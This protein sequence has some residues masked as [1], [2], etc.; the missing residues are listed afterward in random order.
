MKLLLLALGSFAAM[1]GSCAQPAGGSPSLCRIAESPHAFRGMALTVEGLLLVSRH[2]SVLT[3]AGCE[4]GVAIQWRRSEGGLAKLDDV[5]E[6]ELAPE[7]VPR[8]VRIRVTG[9][10]KQARTPDW[11]GLQGWYIDLNGADVLSDSAATS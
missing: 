2:G 5:V 4:R 11:I 8:A 9:E 10:M 1:A 6:R 7:A 3:D